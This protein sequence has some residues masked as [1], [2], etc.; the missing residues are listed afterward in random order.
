MRC[1]LI[2]L[3]FGH[4]NERFF[5]LHKLL[6]VILVARLITFYVYFVDGFVQSNVQ[7]RQIMY[8]K[9]QMVPYF[10]NWL[11][12]CSKKY[13]FSPAYLFIFISYIA[14]TVHACHYMPH[15]GI[16]ASIM[17]STPDL[18]STVLR[19]SFNWWLTILHS[20]QLLII[21]DFDVLPNIRRGF[22]FKINLK[23][24]CHLLFRV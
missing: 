8:H 19:T 5:F 12:S 10:V 11:P 16:N 20:N 21:Y 6:F 3:L 22:P 2:R 14:C 18:S 17:K 4:N 23:K 15:G 24:W 13:I 9:Q 7:V 1:L